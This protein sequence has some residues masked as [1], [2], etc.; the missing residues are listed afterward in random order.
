M[1]EHKK[2]FGNYYGTS[3]MSFMEIMKRSKRPILDIDRLGML[4]IVKSI[5]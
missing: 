1:L 5:K 3:K 4:D 2:V